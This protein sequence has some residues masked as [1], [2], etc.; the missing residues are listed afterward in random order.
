MLNRHLT[1]RFLFALDHIEHGTITVTT[2]DARIHSFAGKNPGAHAKMHLHDWSVVRS[3]MRHGD[4]ALAETYRSGFWESEDLTQLFLFG[5]QNQYSL[6]GYVQGNA[7][8]RLASRLSYFFTRN[9]LKGSQQNI[10]AHYDLGNDFYSLWLDPS[11]TYSSAIFGCEKESLQDAQNRKYDR[12]LDRLNPSGS[13]LEIGCGWG[14]FAARALQTGDYAIKGLTLSKY[15]HDY[16]SGRFEKDAVIALEDYRHQKGL[17]DQIVSIEMFEAVG[18]K[19]WPIYFAK[20]KSLLSNQGKAMIQT[21]TIGDHYFERY[22]RGGDAIRT[23]IFPGG[24]LPSPSRFRKECEK[25]G[26]RIKDEFSFGQD[27][28]LTLEHW[29]KNFDEKVK[30]IK[31]LGFDQ[32]FVRMWRFYLTCCIAAFRHGRTDV[33]QWELDHAA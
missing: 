18:E 5:L 2:P 7:F 13:L 32:K 28:A 26:L 9:T 4:V 20:L 31:A 8:G 33:V 24:M 3:M 10:H 6:D 29:L 16:A 12:V 19:F 1:S 23:F 22:R 21:I 25:A 17:Y 14:G 11:M 30:E 15:Q 27:Y